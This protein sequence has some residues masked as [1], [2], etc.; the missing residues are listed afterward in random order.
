[1]N[2]T[3]LRH[4]VA[5]P[6][7][8]CGGLQSMTVHEAKALSIHPKSN[9]LRGLPPISWVSVAPVSGFKP[10]SVATCSSSSPTAVTG[11]D[12]CVAQPLEGSAEDTSAPTIASI[13]SED[14]ISLGCNVERPLWSGE[15]DSRSATTINEGQGKSMAGSGIGYLLRNGRRPSRH[16]TQPSS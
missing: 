13:A 5:Q 8:Q 2:R 1:M 9:R 4:T 6:T 7:C 15:E 3:D 10:L 12:G 11:A 16:H 14:L